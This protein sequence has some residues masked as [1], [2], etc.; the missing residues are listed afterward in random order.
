MGEIPNVSNSKDAIKVTFNIN[1]I[2]NPDF[3]STKGMITRAKDVKEVSTRINLAI[4]NGTEKIRSISQ[5]KSDKDFGKISV[6]LPKGNFKII[7]IAHSGNGSATITA[8]NEISFN[9]NKVTDTFLCCQD[10][11]VGTNNSFNL[12][13]ERIVAAVRFVFKDAIPEKV[14]K[15]KFYYTGGSSTLDALTGFGCKNSRQTEY[16]EIANDKH[17]SNMQFDLFTFPKQENNG[18]KMTVTALDASGNTVSERK[19]ENIK[20]EKG[21]MSICTGNFFQENIETDANTISFFV[22]DEWKIKNY[23]Y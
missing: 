12:T 23:T 5:T 2:S 6:S 18:L 4:F 8:P 21:V 13:M 17:G 16:R 20:V 1:P 7:A 19:F 9:K 14:S 10:I 11:S 3:T 15:M 22:N